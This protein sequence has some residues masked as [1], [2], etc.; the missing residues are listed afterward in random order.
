MYQA[1]VLTVRTV[2]CLICTLLQLLPGPKQKFVVR[3]ELRDLLQC[4]CVPPGH[5][6]HLDVRGWRHQQG[7]LPSLKMGAGG[8]WQKAASNLARTPSCL[9][10][11]TWRGLWC[12]CRHRLHH[13]HLHEGRSGIRTSANRVLSQT[14]WPSAAAFRKETQLCDVWQSNFTHVF[15]TLPHTSVASVVWS[16]TWPPGSCK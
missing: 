8:S 11:L 15:H 2:L 12:C 9:N 16:A 3:E 10:T 13:S 1:T 7:M 14:L 5:H 6:P 4:R